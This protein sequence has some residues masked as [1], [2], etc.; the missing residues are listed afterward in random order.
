MYL[1]VKG[2]LPKLDHHNL[3]FVDDWKKN[4]HDIYGSK[5]LPEKPSIYVCKPSQTDPSVAPKGF[6]N[7]FVLVPLPS[8]VSMTKLAAAK[9]A[10][11]YITQI[12][13]MTGSTFADRIVSKTVFRPDEF[14]E[15]FHSWQNTALGPSHILTQSAFFRTPN[16]SKKVKNLYYVGGSTVPGIG[17]PMCLIGAELIYKRLAGV[18][19]G[20]R[21][22]VIK[23]VS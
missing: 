22:A 3:L 9:L 17:L 7:V 12:E 4:F 13:E 15:N 20:G 14:G 23:A 21:V 10:D 6:E 8:G 1:G 5:H 19:K 2:T 11:R 18:K 16:I